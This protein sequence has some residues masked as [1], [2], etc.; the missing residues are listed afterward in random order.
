M[1]FKIKSN[2]IYIYKMNAI[3]RAIGFASR[4]APKISRGIGQAAAFSRNI[5]QAAKTVRNIG[6]AVNTASGG[7]LQNS[8]LYNKA[9]EVAGKVEQ[10]ANKIQRVADILPA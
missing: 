7:R 10:G 5:G 1:T 2:I 3:M 6:Q 8:N 9:I 4:V